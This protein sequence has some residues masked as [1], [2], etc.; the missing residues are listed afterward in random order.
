M[1]DRAR[2]GFRLCLIRDPRPEELD[3]IVQLHDAANAAFAKDLAKAGKMASEPLGPLPS[4]ADV[5]D[6]AA[7]TV[8]GN[9]LLNLDET[10]MKR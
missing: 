10:L 1:K 5:A 4:G 6:L 9:V 8:V 3:K 7:W 2:R